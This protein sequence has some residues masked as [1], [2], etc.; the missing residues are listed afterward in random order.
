MSFLLFVPFEPVPEI[1]MIR[2][3]KIQLTL[4]DDPHAWNPSIPKQMTV[5]C[6]D[7]D[8]LWSDADQQLN[9]WAKYA[10]CF[11]GHHR[12][13]FTIFYQDCVKYKGMVQLVNIPNWSLANHVEL[14]LKTR[15]RQAQSFWAKHPS[16]SWVNRIDGKNAA[17]AQA[18]LI[19]HE[20]GMPAS[21]AA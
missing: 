20:V 3:T 4:V 1:A 15:A 21:K 10:P 8:D 7:T 19:S 14:V 13:G 12:V 17:Q 6:L 16:L 11:G 18:F 9:A 5:T 2:C